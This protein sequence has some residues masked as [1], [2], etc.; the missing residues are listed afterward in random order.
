MS[1]CGD[2]D[3]TKSRKPWKRVTK[4]SLSV[5]WGVHICTAFCSDRASRNHWLSII[6]TISNDMNDVS[7]KS[8]FNNMTKLRL[9]QMS[10]IKMRHPCRM[11]CDLSLPTYSKNYFDLCIGNHFHAKIHY[12]LLQ[13]IYKCFPRHVNFLREDIFEMEEHM[14]SIIIF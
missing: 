9:M 11:F 3:I 8:M 4:N 10:S 14:C 7:N 12:A 6:V 13:Y 1:S 5:S 2:R